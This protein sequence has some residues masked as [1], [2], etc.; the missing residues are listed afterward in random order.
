MK[1]L[2]LILLCL[3][4]IGFAQNWYPI[5]NDIDGEAAGDQSGY[6]V[7]L[8]SDGNTVAIGAVGN[9]ANG[10]GA[11]HVRIYE[12]SGGFWSQIGN[13]IDG[14]VANDYSGYSVSLSSDGNTVA[15]GAFGNAG[16]GSNAGHVRIYENSGGSWSQIGQDIDGEAAGDYSGW[17]VS[18]SSDGNTV[19]IGALD[20]DGNG[21]NA[22]HVRIYENSGGSWSQIGND[23]DGE[24]AGDQSGYSVCLSSDGNTVAIGAIGN[25]ANG[26]GAGHVRIYENSG[27]FWSQIGNDIDGEVANDYSGSSVS[28]SSDGNTVA[29]GADG[30]AGN[31]SYSGHVRIYE[32][33]GGSWSQI[34]NDIDGEV[35]NDQSGY[36]VS[37]SSDGNTVAIGAPYNAGNGT[38]SGHVRIYENSGG[39]W[40]QIG[41][42]IDGE[43]AGDQSGYSVCLSS[44]GNTVAI[45]APYNDGIGSNIAGHVRV[46]N[47]SNPGCTDPT[48]CNYDYLAN[49]DDGSCS[50]PSSSSTTI[51]ACDSYSWNGTTYTATGVH[52]F[53]STNANGCDSIATLNLIINPSTTSSVVVTECDSYSWN[54]T[55]Y[56][57][58]GVHA[59]AS[60]NSNGCDSTA[61]LNLTINASTTSSVDVT[62]CDS[63]SWNGTTYTASG[64]HAF[65]STNANGCDSIATLNLT[66]NLSTTLFDTVSICNGDT[67][68]VLN[69]VYTNSGN[70]I[71]SIVNSNGCFS[72][73]YTN[74]TVSNPLSVTIAQVV[75][76]VLESTVNGGIM[77]YDYLWNNFATTP[78]ITISSNGSYWLVVTDSLS[79]PNDTAFYE[80]TN[81]QTS[82]SEFGVDALSIYPNPSSDLFNI[83][84]TS[85]VK[86]SLVVRLVNVI[87]GYILEDKLADFEGDYKRIIN[88][89]PY[90]KGMYFLEIETY[91]GIINK[92][93]ILQ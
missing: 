17:S 62:E 11:G 2:L 48:A 67:Y 61:T 65:A 90:S 91:D 39:S 70:Y 88:L 53:A 68:I 42:D 5:G 15:I 32:N 71:D 19:A 9:A 76:S 23:I 33:S 25:A 43:A 79:C 87:G 38:Y 78:N 3:P 37:L 85:Y 22:G 49:T 12:N 51:T 58:S 89:A 54:G 57:A 72:L 16:N 83:E 55:T 92:K 8:S 28:L 81:F 93:L 46:Y 74:L 4:I 6:S 1:K 34:G 7:S 14:E 24:A 64:V 77:P 35:A 50:Y 80:V 56:T 59:F 20:N 86:Q 41:N 10:S 63:Y 44:D 29:I 69:S 40:S 30:N 73:I 31:G 75:G 21:S 45:G 66:V 26:S 13:D 82:I 18:L 27:G 36:S 60:T 52:A 84:F 47:L